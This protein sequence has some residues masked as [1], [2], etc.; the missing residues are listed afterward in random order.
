MCQ[1][2][3]VTERFCLCSKGSAEDERGDGVAK[4]AKIRPMR[5]EMF[6][7]VRAKYLRDLRGF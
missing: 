2:A 3:M 5:V 4:Y 7:C 6:L 1:T